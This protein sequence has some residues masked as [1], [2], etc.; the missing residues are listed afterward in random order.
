MGKPVTFMQIKNRR[1]FRM[2][3]L[4]L[5]FALM[6][7]HAAF[8]EPGDSLESA[9][10]KAQ[11]EDKIVLLSLSTSWCHWCQAMDELTYADPGVSK[12]ID[13]SY[14]R[15]RVDQN[16]RPDVASRYRDF[17]L[18][19]MV[20]L[21]S[22]GEEIVRK[23]GF[24]GP[25]ALKSLLEAVVDD[26]S[27]GPSAAREEKIAFPDRPG[28]TSAVRSELQTR[29]EARHDA[30][31][32][33]WTFGTKLFDKDAI[34][35]GI[36]LAAAGDKTQAARTRAALNSTRQLLDPV[37]GG[38]FQ[39]RLVPERGPGDSKAVRYVRLQIGGRFDEGGDNWNDPHFEKPLGVQ[40]QALRMF[41]RGFSQW[42]APEDLEA[43][44]NVRGYVQRV[45]T[46]A[47]GAFYTGQSSGVG[48]AGGEGVYFATDRKRR[49]AFATPAIDRSLYPRENG[50]MIAALCAFHAAA[51]DDSALRE[52]ERAARWM[53]DNRG[54]MS[55]GF[56]RGDGNEA[57][58]YL[59]DTLAMGEAFL[60]LHDATGQREWLQ[61]AEAAAQFIQAHFLTAPGPGF[62]TATSPTGF[63]VAQRPDPVENAELV[64]F[65][66]QLAERTSGSYSNALS[67]AM[68][69][70]S[71][72]QS[73]A[74]VSP[75]LA[76]LADVQFGKSGARAG[77]KP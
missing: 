10:A 43:A 45:L 72:E 44:R 59:G 17:E 25:R 31:D 74:A 64:R 49:E 68:R 36:S 24:L 15:V 23:Q 70:L 60:A 16:A 75:A 29:F 14:V 28:L 4:S 71:A 19:F 62:V 30:S 47:D 38:V 26:P 37:W 39:S 55:G 9:F 18:P 69:Y 73:A 50:W 8:A 65:I 58:F 54:M 40:A 66:G 56:S 11:R 6:A 57:G 35:F 33:G 48:V 34:E 5:C 42:R 32:K 27:P 63:A 7:F 77:A 13:D 41:S 46:D 2:A 67:S 53:I 20:I 21:N 76:L 12:L 3:A 1:Y 52:A 51:A 61:R 22:R